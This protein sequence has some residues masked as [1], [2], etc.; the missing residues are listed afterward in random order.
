MNKKMVCLR[1]IG[2]LMFV[3]GSVA[4][5][6][7]RGNFLEKVPGCQAVATEVAKSCEGM[8]GEERHA[9]V[10]GILSQ[11]ANAQCKT[12]LA[13]RRAAWKAKH[14]QEESQGK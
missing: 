1:L 11:P 7:G 10:K 12:A 4:V 9:C 8:K 6:H 3:T 2:S 14:E 13:Q 5:A